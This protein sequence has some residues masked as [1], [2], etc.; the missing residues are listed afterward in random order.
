MKKII[1]LM[2]AVISFTSGL[3][4]GKY[5]ST[6][7]DNFPQSERT[8]HSHSVTLTIKVDELPEEQSED[9]VKEETITA[10]IIT[11]DESEQLV[12]PEQQTIESNPTP[13]PATPVQSQAPEPPVIPAQPPES[14]IPLPTPEQM[15]TEEKSTEN[16]TEF[17]ISY[18]ISYAKNYAQSIGLQFDET[19][20]ACWDNP[21]SANLNR[22]GI[23]K[24]IES[25]LNRYKNIEGFTAVWIWYVQSSDNNYNLYIG[26]A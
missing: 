22:Q 5:F 26:Y 9:N 23:Q 18:W 20:T 12:A 4:G 10:E 6:N 15:I 3:F 25:R 1:V 2:I 17:D 21:I 11:P 24:D 16:R 19:A 13:Q 8:Y 7:Q 14:D